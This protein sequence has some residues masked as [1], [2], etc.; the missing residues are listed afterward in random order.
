[1]LATLGASMATAQT[2]L[3]NVAIQ[4]SAATSA[5]SVEDV[6]TRGGSPR[7]GFYHYWRPVTKQSLSASVPLDFNTATGDVVTTGNYFAP[8]CSAYASAS[9]SLL[10]RNSA[11]TF[12][13]VGQTATTALATLGA[14]QHCTVTALLSPRFYFS[15]PK[16]TLVTISFA[17]TAPTEGNFYAISGEIG[18]GENGNPHSYIVAA[19]GTYCFWSTWKTVAGA[20]ASASKASVTL[21]FSP[22]N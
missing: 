13:F 19:G 8:S 15:V 6:Y 5:L 12:R 7:S 16:D 11:A 4:G 22:P 9:T 3:T 2:L 17:G 18:P 14:H 21:K 1:M 10:N 20:K